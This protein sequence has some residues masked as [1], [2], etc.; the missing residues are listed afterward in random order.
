[1]CGREGVRAGISSRRSGSGVP[2][3]AAFRCKSSWLC[4]S[5]AVLS[6]VSYLTFLSLDFLLSKMETIVPSA[7]GCGG[8]WERTNTWKFSVGVWYFIVYHGERS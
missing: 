7:C 3:L 6:W 5:L 4:S 8:S 2:T 1:M